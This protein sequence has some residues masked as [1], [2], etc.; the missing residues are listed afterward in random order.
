MDLSKYPIRP[1]DRGRSA[2]MELAWIVVQSLFVHSWL[3]GSAH[4]VWLLRKFGARIGQGVVIKQFVRVK[5]PWRLS[6]GE[7]TWIG[8][9]AW[10]D[11]LAQV[12]IGSHCCISQNAYLC[13]GSH[14]W[15]SNTFDLITKPITIEDQA[16]VA[17]G[18][19]VAPGVTIGRAAVLALGA[20][21]LADLQPGWIYQG[22]P[23]QP[24]KPRGGSTAAPG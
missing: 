21:A 5:F 15:K 16:W 4:R 7:H 14:D 3:P 11:N 18:S 6:I 13:T 22:N 19:Q 10:I 8:E 24:V 20:V 17:A 12:N 9:G 2:L 23:A 1:F